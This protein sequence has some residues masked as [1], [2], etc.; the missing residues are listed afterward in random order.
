MAY[1]LPRRSTNMVEM[2]FK[3]VLCCAVQYIVIWFS[4][5]EVLHAL[6]YYQH[7]PPTFY[8][9]RAISEKPQPNK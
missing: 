2:D 1:Y 3:T 4:E 5:H 6:G 8:L 9:P 7:P